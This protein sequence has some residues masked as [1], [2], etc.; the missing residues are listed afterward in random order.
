[1]PEKPDF[2]LYKEER[3]R[4]KK[5]IEKVF[6]DGSTFL[7]YPVKVVYMDIELSGDY[8]AKAAFAVSKKL[9]K[10]AVD[11]N[12]I[13]R[14]MRE[15]YRLNRHHLNE[16]RAGTARAIVFIYIGKEI[17]EYRKLEKAMVRALTLVR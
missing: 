17:V 6:A 8:P 14:R 9:F 7:V 4:S 13:K 3:L 10:K 16:G 1:M 15:V 5:L 12:L 2:R 11:R